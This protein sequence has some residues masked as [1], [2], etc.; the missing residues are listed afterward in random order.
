MSRI[1]IL[2]INIPAKVEVKSAPD[3]GLTVKG[4]GGTLSRTLPTG[5]SVAIENNQV[6]VKRSSEEI[7][8]RALHGLSRSLIANMIQG[9]TQGFKKEL[10]VV[11][12]GYRV[13]S[14]GQLLE[15]TL[16]FSHN[17]I[18]QV[19]PEVK[20][21]AVSEKGKS[22]LIILESADNQLLGMIA[23]KIRSLRKP[24]PYKGKGI[25]YRNETVRRKA[26]KAAA[27][28]TAKP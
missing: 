14:D 26:G 12:V 19:P 18:F 1:G 15:L 10:E 5:I 3:N 27:T 6:T 17:I 7:R 20:V 21:K 22:P 28:A 8:D 2:P 11:G 16:G 25:R 4:P 23:A 24:E 9:V 13:S